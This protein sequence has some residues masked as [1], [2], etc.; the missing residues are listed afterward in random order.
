[1]I[2]ECAMDG[3]AQWEETTLSNNYDQKL[4]G[5]YVNFEETSLKYL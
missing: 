4:K 3:T 1:M 5:W 2:G